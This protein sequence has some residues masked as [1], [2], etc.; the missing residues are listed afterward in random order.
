MTEL[1]KIETKLQNSNCDKTEKLKQPQ[2]LKTQ[3]V[4]KLKKSEL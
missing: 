1:K 4:R 3:I 2:N